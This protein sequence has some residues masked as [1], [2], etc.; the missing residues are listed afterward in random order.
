MK[1]IFTFFFSALIAMGVSAQTTLEIEDYG[2]FIPD[3]NDSITRAVNHATIN[4]AIEQLGQS[5]GGVLEL[6]ADTFYIGPNPR[7]DGQDQ[8]IAIAHSNITIM[9]AAVGKTVLRTNGTFYEGVFPGTEDG[10]YKLN[11][12][13]GRGSGIWL[14]GTDDKF[15]PLEN[16]VLKDFELDGQAGWTGDY[17]ID[18]T[19]GSDLGWDMH[20]SGIVVSTDKYVDNVLLENIYVHH[21]RGE[22]MYVGGINTGKLTVR[23][24][25]S[26]N[27][28]ASCCNLAAS[29][30]L[31]ENCDF[32]GP[33]RFWIEMG[34]RESLSLNTSNKAVFRNID[35]HDAKEDKGLININQ[36][37]HSSYEVIFEENTI[38]ADGMGVFRIEGGIGGPVTIRNNT[39]NN[40]GIVFRAFKGYGWILDPRNS[41]LTVENN[42]ISNG[43][44]LAEFYSSADN[45][46]IKGNTFV[47]KGVD[48]SYSVRYGA[49]DEEGGVYENIRI[50]E[51]EFSDCAAPE[52]NYDV[53]DGAGIHADSERPFFVNN[54]YTD[55]NKR[56]GQSIFTISS[57]SPKVTPHYEEMEVFATVD[58]DVIELATNSY[59]DGQIVKIFGGEAGKKVKFAK[60][61]SSYIVDEDKYL[62]GSD[63]LSFYYDQAG[64]IWVDM[65]AGSISVTGVSLD[66]DNTSV[67]KGGTFQLTAILAPTYASNKSISWTSDHPSVATV[68]ENG[69]V[70]G[71]AK[72][73]ATITVTTEDGGFTDECV[74]TCVDP[75]IWTGTQP[76]KDL[77]PTHCTCYGAN[78]GTMTIDVSKIEGGSG[79]YLFSMQGNQGLEFW[80]VLVDSPLFGTDNIQAS[81]VFTNLQGGN[82]KLTIYDAENISITCT[83]SANGNPIGQVVFE[84]RELQ[85]DEL[86]VDGVICGDVV[87]GE[88]TIEIFGGSGGTYNLYGGG[89]IG[90]YK[91]YY[92]AVSNTAGDILIGTVMLEDD[93]NSYTFDV[94]AKEFIINVTDENGCSI[95]DTVGLCIPVTG[96]TVTPESVSV[97]IDETYQLSETVSPSNAAN[98]EVTWS[99]DNSSVA[100]V[101]ATG[102][103]TAVAVG[104]A[105]VT[106]T[107]ED[108][109]FNASATINVREKTVAV[110]G[111]AV[112][113][114]TADIKVDEAY[115]LST[116]VLPSNATN[117]EVTWSSDNSPVATV[118]AS[119]EVTGIAAGTAIVTV[120]T[121]DGSYTASATIN[122]IDNTGVVTGAAFSETVKIYPN[123][124]SDKLY[125]SYENSE[126]REVIVELVNVTGTMLY[127]NQTSEGKLEI[128]CSLFPHGLYFIRIGSAEG[129]VTT[130]KVLVN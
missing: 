77:K 42:I 85:I 107:T 46:L 102:A 12:A 16:I 41:N 63:T 51:N 94:P 124:T 19:N 92:V 10:V 5:G 7:I 66:I 23:N 128:D 96:I 75:I 11:R 47:G 13:G 6:P 110:I 98:Q 127:Q 117:K 40:T 109:S 130:K 64:A 67:A 103:V 26:G 15:N 57:S 116:A 73:T 44:S 28:N 129:A 72:G 56:V 123:P 82:Y 54:V 60:G 78:T 65:N 97:E 93:V 53:G 34:T 76:V 108:G 9:G 2:Q 125:L 22:V 35:F 49:G 58:E 99:S 61:Q 14:K 59:P 95:E 105:I 111:I 43:G 24:V 74:V 4:G 112:F 80:D 25:T 81:N 115:Q 45:V 84:P 113:P 48:Q 52:E 126:A 87:S 33:S 8:A 121:D 17:T 29:E 106:V 20:H 89:K 119:G 31:V 3:I 30:L 21:Y 39:L 90:D 120:T 55:C 70:S 36:G 122:V 104:T 100:T 1:N 114:E 79:N 50:E 118:S 38:E 68:D 18:Y 62:D 101:S 69:V 83:K 88:V 27:T 91:H 86:N 37:D 32:G 71:V